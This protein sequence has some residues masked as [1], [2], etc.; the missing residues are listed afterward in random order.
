MRHFMFPS[1]FV[2]L[3]TL[4]REY[5]APQR[6]RMLSQESVSTDLGAARQRDRQPLRLYPF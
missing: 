3:W 1:A 4:I 5:L 2:K 6:R